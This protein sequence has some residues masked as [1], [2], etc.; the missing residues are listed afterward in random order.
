LEHWII[1]PI[2][3]VLHG[4]DQDAYRDYVLRLWQ[5]FRRQATLPTLSNNNKQCQEEEWQ[6]PAVSNTLSASLLANVPAAF[7]LTDHGSLERG[8]QSCCLSRKKSVSNA[9]TRFAGTAVLCLDFNRDVRL[10]HKGGLPGKQGW[11]AEQHV[12]AI[13][14]KWLRREAVPTELSQFLQSL[15][16]VQTLTRYRKKAISGFV[17]YHPGNTAS[18]SSDSFVD[19]SGHLREPELHVIIQGSYLGVKDSLFNAMAWPRRWVKQLQ[20]LNLTEDAGDEN[21]CQLRAHYGYTKIARQ[22]Y[23]QVQAAASKLEQDGKTVGRVVVSGHSLGSAVGAVLV[24]LLKVNGRFS[25]V[26]AFLFAQPHSFTEFR[27]C[28]RVR[29]PDAD[30]MMQDHVLSIDNTNDPVVKASQLYQ[31]LGTSV[32]FDGASLTGALKPDAL[33]GECIR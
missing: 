30:L 1:E 19:D 10:A 13:K 31:G 14:A 5:E 20:K 28:S 3:D 25:S 21:D 29:D 15:Q 33:C 7:G 23:P 18:C 24:K 32:R 12:E 8:F 26:Q 9:W 16:F 22:L 11:S 2:E 6:Q 27:S 4:H 17:A